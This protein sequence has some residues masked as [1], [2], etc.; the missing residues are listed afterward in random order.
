MGDVG[1]RG[2]WMGGCGRVP[3]VWRLDLLEQMRGGPGLGGSGGLGRHPVLE[4][5]M[6]K[7]VTLFYAE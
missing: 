1:I 5:L 2:A 7:F 6:L 4:I 3:Y